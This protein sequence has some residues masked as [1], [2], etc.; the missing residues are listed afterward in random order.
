MLP[1]L[2]TALKEIVDK[3]NLFSFGVTS[4]SSDVRHEDTTV[5]LLCYDVAN[6]AYSK[7]GPEVEFIYDRH[8]GTHPTYRILKKDI[9]DGNKRTRSVVYFYHS[10]SGEISVEAAIGEDGTTSERIM[11]E[12]A[13]GYKEI[14]YESDGLTAKRIRVGRL[15]SE[16]PADPRTLVV[17]EALY[18]DLGTP[19]E[20]GAKTTKDT[21]ETGDKAREQEGERARQ[22][23]SDKSRR[24]KR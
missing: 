13:I 15:M 21:R 6:E 4:N 16:T 23:R 14:T 11:K 22:E 1:E 5:S 7:L 19:S 9:M 10:D 18:S 12:V 2:T 20:P 3:G 8:H 17:E 24:D